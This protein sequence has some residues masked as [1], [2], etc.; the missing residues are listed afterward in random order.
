[1]PRTDIYARISL[2]PPIA[3]LLTLAG[4]EIAV[5]PGK[6]DVYNTLHDVY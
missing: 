6:V 5:A 4:T 3:T 2:A 1:M